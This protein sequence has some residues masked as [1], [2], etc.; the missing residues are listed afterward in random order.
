MLITLLA[1]SVAAYAG[2]LSALL[3]QLERRHHAIWTEMGSP[4]WF[5]LPRAD[6]WML[7]KFLFGSGHG[8]ELHP[9]VRYLATGTRLTLV[10]ST[11]MFLL[12]GLQQCSGPGPEG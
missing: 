1:I 2:T 4:P 5:Y 6:T 9:T 3:F 12:F 10:L 8:D 7:L 11:V